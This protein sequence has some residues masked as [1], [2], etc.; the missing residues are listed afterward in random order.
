MG[1]EVM[2]K[3]ILGFGSVGNDA[4]GNW[5]VGKLNKALQEYKNTPI[6]NSY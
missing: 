5:L 2:L 1:K 3:V 6:S 4:N